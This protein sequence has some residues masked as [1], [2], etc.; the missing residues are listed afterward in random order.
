M[1]DPRLDRF[2]HILRRALHRAELTSLARQKIKKK[3]AEEEITEDYA[4]RLAEKYKYRE[5]LANDRQDAMRF[6]WYFTHIKR[7]TPLDELRAWLDHKIIEEDS[8]ND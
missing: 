7:D 6:R 2:H 3:S 1:S 4:E 8:R 5:L